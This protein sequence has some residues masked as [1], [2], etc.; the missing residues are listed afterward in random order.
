MDYIIRPIEKG[1]CKSPFLL[2]KEEDLPLKVFF[3]RDAEKASDAF[4]TRTYVAVP[5]DETDRRVLGYIS[6]MNAEVALKG[7]HDIEDKPRANRYPNQ[8]AI[9]IARLAVADDVQG[10]GIGCDLVSLG[11]TICLDKIV[12]YIGCR[13]VVVNAK[14]KAVDFYRG[15]F[16]F[17]MLDT[18]GNRD[19]PAPIMWLDL[20]LYANQQAEQAIEA[21]MTSEQVV[22]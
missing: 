6:L 22:E 3:T 9:R 2:S 18:E 20:K 8:P 10:M 4:I 1:D 13:F 5:A 17:V 19:A 21:A 15:K 16:D 7:V 11:L 12:P 14:R